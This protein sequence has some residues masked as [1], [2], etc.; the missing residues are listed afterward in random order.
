MWAA[1]TA[2]L[3]ALACVVLSARRYRALLSLEDGVA[4]SDR[5]GRGSLGRLELLRSSLVEGYGLELVNAVLEAPDQRTAVFGLNEVGS[6]LKFL[7]SGAH[8]LPRSAARIALAF[9]GVLAVL[10]L[11][12]WLQGSGGGLVSA[13]ICLGA[14]L[15]A[16]L[17]CSL[18]AGRSAVHA[19]AQLAG[20]SRAIRA[21]GAAADARFAGR[22]G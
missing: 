20:W 10:Q 5:L 4:F 1:C 22:P 8:E 19:R 13:W 12:G 18:F 14:G 7:L 21:L 6:E 17:T 15:A 16:G 9:G 3:A 11:I 2:L